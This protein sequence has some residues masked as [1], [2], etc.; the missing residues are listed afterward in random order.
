MEDVEAF[1]E[2]PESFTAVDAVTVE[3][4]TGVSLPETDID[5]ATR[6]HVEPGDVLGHPDSA[7]PGIR[8]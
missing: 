8:R 7:R 4:V 6:Q 3:L 2:A 5:A 1:H